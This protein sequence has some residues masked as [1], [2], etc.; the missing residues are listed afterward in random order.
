MLN[1][2]VLFDH[3]GL[4]LAM[5]C[6]GILSVGSF[7]MAWLTWP[8]RSD[9]SP[10]RRRPARRMPRVRYRGARSTRTMAAEIGG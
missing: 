5:L 10:S 2:T 3:P 9:V 6:I 1:L 4:L 8:G 7:V